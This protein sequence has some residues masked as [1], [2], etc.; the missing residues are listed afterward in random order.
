MGLAYLYNR[1]KEH[2]MLRFLISLMIV[3]L[4]DALSAHSPVLNNGNVEMS[5]SEPYLI[6]EPEHS[7]AI[8]SELSGKVHYYRI[9]SDVPFS[10]Y[11]GIT[12]PKLDEC[13]LGQTFSFEVLNSNF[14]RID[15]RDGSKFLWSQWYEKFGKKWY[16]V[17]P[18]IGR[19]FK[20]NRQYDAGSWYVRV[21]NKGNAGK[22]V[23]AIGDKERFGLGAIFKMR[24][25]VKEINRIFWDSANCAS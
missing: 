1:S 13:D 21:F 22:Y 9:D 19:A 8:F 23:L 12:T 18:E 2:V 16:W 14:K 17:G 10:F 20:S 15:G 25:T 6:N 24:G 7:K 5:K 4:P 3:A 11:V